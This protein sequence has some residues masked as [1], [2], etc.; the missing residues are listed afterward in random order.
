MVDILL[1]IFQ[2]TYS[3]SYTH[4]DVYKR[5]PLMRVYHL[6]LLP[7]SGQS[8]SRCFIV[9]GDSPSSPP[10]EFLICTNFKSAMVKGLGMTI[11]GR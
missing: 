1:V 2:G 10:I 6:S 8:G 9:P 4:L 3:V 11:A 7:P 5:Q